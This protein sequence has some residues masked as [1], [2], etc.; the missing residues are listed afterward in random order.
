VA[1]FEFLLWRWL[2]ARN[3]VQLSLAMSRLDL[4]LDRDASRPRGRSRVRRDA[5]RFFWIIVSAFAFT[6]PG[7]LATR[8]STAASPD[9]FLVA[10]AATSCWCSAVSCPALTMFA[11]QNE[12]RRSS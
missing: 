1:L 3:L 5:Q 8:S 4:R 10:I 6:A 2:W 12:P 9:G 11:G 7:V